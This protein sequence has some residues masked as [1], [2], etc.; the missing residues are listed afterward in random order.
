MAGAARREDADGAACLPGEGVEP[1]ELRTDGGGIPEDAPLPVLM[2]IAARLMGAFYAETVRTAGV[3][4]SPAGLGVLRVLLAQDGLKSSEVAARGGSSPGT[5]TAVVN[6]LTREGYVK[7]RPDASDRR[8]IRLHVTDKGRA[9]CDQYTQLGG[10]LW[11]EAFDFVS[12]DD[13][14]VV[15]RF[16]AEMISKFS[17]LAREERGT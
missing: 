3:R 2:M 4:M 1:W 13:E 14:V 10:P 6:T 7:R 16:F 17:K 5:L 15:R 12:A 8:V 11:R 9:A